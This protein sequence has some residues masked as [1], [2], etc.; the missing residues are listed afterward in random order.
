MQ[1]YA[2]ETSPGASNRDRGFDGIAPPSRSLLVAAGS[3]AIGRPI[4]IAKTIPVAAAAAIIASIIAPIVPVPAAAKEAAPY[5]TVTVDAMSANEGTTYEMV[6]V[7]TR[8]AN[9]AWSAI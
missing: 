4:A 8:S 6:T 9:E 3:L 7:D 2:D 1:L 5:E